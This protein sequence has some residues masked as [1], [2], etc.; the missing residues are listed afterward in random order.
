MAFSRARWSASERAWLA[1]LGGGVLLGVAVQDLGQ[2]AE[3]LVRW[4]GWGDRGGDGGSFGMDLV[5]AG[6]FGGGTGAGG[7]VGAFRGVG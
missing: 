4:G 3:R 5:V 1:G 7:G 2:H 6:Q